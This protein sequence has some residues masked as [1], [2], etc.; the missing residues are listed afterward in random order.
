MP[1][2]WRNAKAIEEIREDLK[3]TKG[4]RVE[5]EELRKL[6]LKTVEYIREERKGKPLVVPVPNPPKQEAIEP[7]PPI[8]KKKKSKWF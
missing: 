4:L 2:C 3:G 5:L 7:P 8:E 1:D 6:V